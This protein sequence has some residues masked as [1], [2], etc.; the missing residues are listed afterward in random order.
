MNIVQNNFQSEYESTAALADMLNT[1]TISQPFTA[2]GLK[3]LT[4]WPLEKVQ[5][6]MDKLSALY[7][8]EMIDNDGMQPKFKIMLDSEKRKK[9]IVNDTELVARNYLNECAMRRTILMIIDQES[10]KEMSK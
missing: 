1:R 9:Y 7:F 10:E 2:L 4:E 8:L 6:A 5:E 3:A